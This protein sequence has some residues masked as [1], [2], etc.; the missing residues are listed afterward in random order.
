MSTDTTDY[1]PVGILDDRDYLFTTLRTGDV[2]ATLTPIDWGL[3]TGGRWVIDAQSVPGLFSISYNPA[4]DTT[5]RLIVN[6]AAL[7]PAAGSGVAVTVHYYDRN[8]IDGYGN[9][10]PGKGIAETLVYNVEAGSSR[11]LAGFGS[12]FGLGA[13]TPSANP[14]LATLS[15]GAFI[16]VWQAPSGSVVGQLRSAAGAAQGQVTAISASSDGAVEGAPVVAALAD[17][18]SV[19]AYTSTDV[20]GTRIAY[21]VLDAGG[22]PGA[23]VVIGAAGLDTAMPSVTALHDGSFAVA[24]RSAGQVH[25]RTADANGNPQGSEQV[26]GT[27]G[28][29]FSPSIAATTSGYVVAWGELGDG[30]VYAARSGNAPILVSGDGLAASIATAAPQP[31]VTVLAGGGFVVTWDSYANSPWG[32]ASSDIFFQRFDAA[33]NRLGEM[34]QANLDSGGG[35]F[36]ATTVALADGGFLIAWQGAGGDFDGNGVFGRRFGAD[37][38]ARDAREFGINEMRQGDQANPVLSALANGGFAAAWIDTQAD[39]TIQVE[40]RVLAGLEAAPA[41]PT[42]GTATAPAPAAPGTSGSGA[43]VGSQRIDGQGGI[44]IITFGGRKSAYGIT[45]GSNGVLVNDL[46]G[47]SGTDTLVNIERLQFADTALALDIEGNAGQAY[48]LYQAAL[49]RAPDKDG[50]GFW[51][52]ALDNGMSLEEVARGFTGSTEFMSRFDAGTD[53]QF[54]DLLYQNVL[55]R[56]GDAEGRSFWVGALASGAAS[57]ERV[58]ADFSE[59]AENKAQLSGALANGIEYNPMVSGKTGNDVFKAMLGSQNYDGGAGIDTLVYEGGRND[60]TLERGATG[61]TVSERVGGS[62]DTLVSVE[63]ITFAD[64]SVALDIDGHAGQA[65]RLYQAAL[66]RTPDKAGLGSWMNSL[67]H[68]TSLAEVARG[69]MD[70][71]EFARLYGSSTTDAQ[72]VDLLY[73]N[74]LHRPGDAEGRQFWIDAL[75]VHHAPREQVLVSFSE[76]P[77]N[78][79]QVIGAIQHG[80]EFTPWV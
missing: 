78:Q 38:A 44:D 79:A 52:N 57:R 55:H 80:I 42:P 59:S 3:P 41:A 25:V 70:S 65:Y 6:D 26:Y 76:S 40:A 9:P 29:A 19:V 11:D 71:A 47:S 63:R 28:T 31:T 32:F 20:S 10:L 58:L 17:G 23:E 16:A 43:Q 62:V 12:E 8:Q 33:G 77:E 34:T 24:W 5:A 68:G 51:I 13:A 74:V 14:A 36:E 54:V 49:N 50:L 46:V 69:F 60:F 72:F 2:A 66:N 53:A 22:K 4:T 64:A 73:N 75:S 7:L 15:T 37:G 30:N 21:R 67:D 1:A 39:G 35:R 48:R 27:L 18:R 61:I 45:L 56:P